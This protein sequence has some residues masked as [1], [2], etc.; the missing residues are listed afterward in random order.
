MKKKK[1][2]EKQNANMLFDL[3]NQQVIDCTYY[4]SKGKRR[5]VIGE[6]E[7]D[8]SI[9]PSESVLSISTPILAYSFQDHNLNWVSIVFKFLIGV[10]ES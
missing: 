1:E 6:R 5:A 9:N 4:T 2:D 10:E 7:R 3:S 8:S